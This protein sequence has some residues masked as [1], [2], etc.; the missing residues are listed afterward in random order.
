MWAADTVISVVA[1]RRLDSTFSAPMART[2]FPSRDVSPG[3]RSIVNARRSTLHESLVQVDLDPQS[4]HTRPHASPILHHR[5]EVL[6]RPTHHGNVIER[7][8]AKQEQV[9][10]SAFLDTSNFPFHFDDFRCSGISERIG[11]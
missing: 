1:I 6:V 5:L 3:I 9:G 7:V 4:A 2:R 8:R 10:E 11:Y